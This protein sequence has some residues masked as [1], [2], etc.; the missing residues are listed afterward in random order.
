MLSLDQE[1]P[2]DM[3]K[4]IY[5]IRRTLLTHAD[6]EDEVMLIGMEAFLSN[7]SS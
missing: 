6:I 1:E 7:Y 5:V 4:R 3:I 2:N